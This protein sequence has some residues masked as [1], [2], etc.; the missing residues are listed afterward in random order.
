MLYYRITMGTGFAL[1]VDRNNP[2]AGSQL[3]LAAPTTT[4]DGEPFQLW[5]LPFY[6]D[7]PWNVGFCMINVATQMMAIPQ[8]G[9]S[10][11]VQVPVGNVIP[12]EA[13]WQSNSASGARTIMPLLNENLALNASGNGW[14]PGTKIIVYPWAGGEPNELWKLEPVVKNLAV[15]SEAVLTT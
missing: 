3:I 13:A 12:N 10:N 9:T 11:V 14:F 15:A 7:C 6:P 5:S 8:P 4:G 2:N 1:A